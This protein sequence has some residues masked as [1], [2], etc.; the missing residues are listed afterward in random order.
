MDH[1]VVAIYF[2]GFLFWIFFHAW[3][4]KGDHMP[5]WKMSFNIVITYV[6]LLGLFLWTSELVV[7]GIDAMTNRCIGTGC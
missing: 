6:V 1:V 5:F 3:L 2:V 7:Q 4:F